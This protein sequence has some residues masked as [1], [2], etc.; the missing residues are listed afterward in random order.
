MQFLAC[1]QSTVWPVADLK[2]QPNTVKLLQELVRDLF[3]WP[4]IIQ[5][6]T[7]GV[8]KKSIS[9]AFDFQTQT[10]GLTQVTCS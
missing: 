10:Q 6:Q 2:F 3:P 4:F 1:C 7:Q 5:T 8:G 9:R